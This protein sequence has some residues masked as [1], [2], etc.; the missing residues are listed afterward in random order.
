M[1]NKFSLLILNYTGL[2][3]KPS[4]YAIKWIDELVKFHH[5]FPVNKFPLNIYPRS[6]IEP[7]YFSSA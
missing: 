2:T 3:G 6:N 4:F 5:L 7:P 1:R